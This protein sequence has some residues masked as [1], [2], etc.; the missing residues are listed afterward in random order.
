VIY[1]KEVQTTAIE[2]EPSMD[3]EDELR[4][5]IY[6][7]REIEAERT[8]RDK[9]LEEES[10]KLDE[11][12]EQEIRGTRAFSAHGYLNTKT[13]GVRT[14]GGGTSQHPCSTRVP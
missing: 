8:V 14:F 7:E 4:Q 6:R 3:Y 13:D 5:R 11:E 12:I 1:N 9:Q 10:V 2:T